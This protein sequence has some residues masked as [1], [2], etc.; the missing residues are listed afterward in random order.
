MLQ[1]AGPAHAS[2][3]SRRS[4]TFTAFAVPQAEGYVKELHA[5]WTDSKCYSQLSADGNVLAE[6]H[7]AIEFGLD[8]MTA[9]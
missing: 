8:S 5:C 9:I 4:P 1:Q 3:F 2:A 7:D 6:M